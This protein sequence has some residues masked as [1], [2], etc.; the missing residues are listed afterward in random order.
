MLLTKVFEKGLSKV[1]NVFSPTCTQNRKCCLKRFGIE[2]CFST[3]CCQ[4]NWEKLQQWFRGSLNVWQSISPIYTP[5]ATTDHPSIPAEKQ[6]IPPPPRKNPPSP[7]PRDRSLKVPF[8]LQKRIEEHRSSTAPVGCHVA[9]GVLYQLEWS[10]C[11]FVHHTQ[12]DPG[13]HGSM[14][15]T[16]AAIDHVY[17]TRVL[18]YSFRVWCFVSS[19]ASWMTRYF[20]T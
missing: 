11:V 13:T 6:V 2:Q 20:P 12:L 18:F 5:L 3:F 16:V 4:R 7:S 14:C 17:L 8:I 9:A 15:S 19:M 10:P 1:A